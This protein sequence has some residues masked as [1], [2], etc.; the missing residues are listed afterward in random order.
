MNKLSCTAILIFVSAEALAALPVPTF[1]SST[2]DMPGKGIST[3]EAC[4]T[5]GKKLYY[6]P[7]KQ[8]GATV[9]L[10]KIVTNRSTTEHIKTRSF[11]HTFIDKNEK[12]D[13]GC[14][15]DGN[16]T[17]EARVE[18]RSTLKLQPTNIQEGYQSLAFVRLGANHKGKTLE[19]HH[20]YKAID[21]TVI[22]SFNPVQTY[23]IKAGDMIPVT[24]SARVTRASFQQ[25]YEGNLNCNPSPY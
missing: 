13:L 3:G 25:P 12:I 7:S 20:S 24:D 4:G 14:T 23:V 18:L 10:C 22:D 9:V 16:T 8:N 17:I 11:I 15:I 1:D 2:S 5:G 19:N 6:G 21:V